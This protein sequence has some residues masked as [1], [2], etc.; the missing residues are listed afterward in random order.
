MARSVQLKSKLSLKS[1]VGKPDIK[2]L[3]AGKVAIDLFNVGGT[4]LGIKSG[5]SNFGDWNAFIGQFAAV[6]LDTGEVFKGGQLFLPTIAENFL[7]PAVM[8]AKGNPLEFGF[9][10]G[11]QPMLKP[12]GTESYEYTVKPII[13]TGVVDPLDA[14][15]AKLEAHAPKRIEAP[16]AE[17]T[18][19]NVDTGEYSAA[20]DSEEEPAR[21]DAAKARGKK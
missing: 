12:D 11:I 9:I 20:P 8:E 2:A 4:A 19:Q 7:M 14:M 16:V 5:V 21:H 1:I 17:S 18:G 15:V 10:V 3:H 13:D 6:R